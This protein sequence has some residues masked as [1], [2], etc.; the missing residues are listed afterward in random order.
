MP[1]P[2]SG[3]GYSADS[4]TFGKM[5][6]LLSGS[7]STLKEAATTTVEGLDAGASNHYVGSTMK[8]LSDAAAEIAASFTTLSRGV[9][10]SYD[11][12]MAN[13]D[14]AKHD[15]SDLDLADAPH[16]ETAQGREQSSATSNPPPSR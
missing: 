1:D 13:E 3:K 5:A 8:I 9:S 11:S 7:A 16:S 10:T 12:Y 2:D 14:D 15:F 6:K 4:G